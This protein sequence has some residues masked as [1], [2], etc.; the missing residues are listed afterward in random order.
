MRL[1]AATICASLVF[2]T[3][4]PT[5]AD[6]VHDAI[7]DYA[8]YQNDVSL[9]LDLNIDSARVVNGALARITRNDPERVARGFIAYGA[10]TAAQSPDFARGVERRLGAAG[11]AHVARVLGADPSYARRE[12]G[13]ASAAVRLILGAAR[14]D[15]ARAA[16]AGGRFDGVARTSNAAWITSGERRRATLTSARLTPAARQRLRIGALEASPA[17]EVGAFGGRGFWDALAGRDARPPRAGGAR[18]QRGYSSVTNRML[19][20]GAMILAGADENAHVSMLLD[21]PLTAQ[22]LEMQRLQLRQCLSVSVDAGERTFCLG[23]H[24][25]TGPSACFSAML[26]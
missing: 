11:P 19:T 5:R 3:A 1:F 13:G 24:G 14:A 6:P 26:Q 22:C 4:T 17:D 23:R 12:I 8:L 21:E 16:I 15:S 7:E 10:L 2:M 9:L 25:L 18:E 20:V